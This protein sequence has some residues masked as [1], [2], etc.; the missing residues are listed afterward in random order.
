M[1]AVAGGVSPGLYEK[2]QTVCTQAESGQTKL[3]LDDLGNLYDLMGHIL[4]QH[5]ISPDEKQKIVLATLHGFI[6]KLG[7]ALQ[8][9]EEFAYTV[10]RNLND[11]LKSVR[12][13][14]MSE[15]IQGV[16]V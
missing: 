8:R 5:T 7:E 6:Q 2:L 12:K 11:F 13:E 16:L 9:D 1:K 10:F 15:G 14:M 3:T 4:N